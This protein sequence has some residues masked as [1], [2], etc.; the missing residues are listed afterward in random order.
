LT[1]QEWSTSPIAPGPQPAKPAAIANTTINLRIIAIPC[2]G[3]P[4][5]QSVD[6][7]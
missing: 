5:V 4:A 2:A 3:S 7:G 6:T 1:W